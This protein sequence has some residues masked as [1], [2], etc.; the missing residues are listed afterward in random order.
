MIS[1]TG[2]NLGPCLIELEQYIKYAMVHLNNASTHGV[3]REE[4][5]QAEGRCL[6]RDIWR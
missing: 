5:A 1:N 6:F 3:L 4:E 2:K